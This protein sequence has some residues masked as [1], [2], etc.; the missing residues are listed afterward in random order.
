MADANFYGT[1]IPVGFGAVGGIAVEGLFM[2]M[3]LGIDGD[4]LTSF[5]DPLLELVLELTG[6][7]VAFVGTG[8]ARTGV[9]VSV[10]FSS[11]LLASLAV[12]GLA[13]G[14]GRADPTVGFLMDCST[15]P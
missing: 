14:E 4:D 10:F 1:F 13:A 12:I 15:R 3:V 8:R 7:L 5:G 6:T 2:P 9:L 11:D